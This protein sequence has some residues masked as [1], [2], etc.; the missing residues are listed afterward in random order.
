MHAK[1]NSVL[2]ALCIAVSAIGQE[3]TPAPVSVVTVEP[4]EA[5]AAQVDGRW[6]V[7]SET[8]RL[9]ALIRVDGEAKFVIVD[10]MF[11]IENG[12]FKLARGVSV[13]A[14]PAEA[15]RLFGVS[16][17]AGEYLVEVVS[18]DPNLGVVKDKLTIQIGKR[19]D[20]P[21]PDDP[22]PPAPDDVPFKSDGLA[23]MV[24]KE[25]SGDALLPAEQSNIFRSVKVRDW[26]NSNCTK[27][28]DNNP[29]CRTWDDDYT[30]ATLANAP[31]DVVAAY[32]ATK[33]AA[34]SLPWVCVANKSKGFSGPLP[35][36][37]DDFIKLLE[38]LK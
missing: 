9:A 11:R 24:V 33:T 27:A 31:S 19:P 18:S 5:T 4:S 1:L 16:G 38:G 22:D 36:N 6:V 17:P 13:T 10:V 12:S 7:A 8:R 2:S 15:G 28:S 26:L 23:V 29:F 35:G 34:K 25:A 21:T 32:K 20:P 14:L 30:D 37:V 3:P